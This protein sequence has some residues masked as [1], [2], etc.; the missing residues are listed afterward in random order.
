M[1]SAMSLW[2]SL[3]DSLGLKYGSSIVVFYSLSS[4]V[5]LRWKFSSILL[6]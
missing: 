4:S 1:L 3:S 5:L 2:S 6:R